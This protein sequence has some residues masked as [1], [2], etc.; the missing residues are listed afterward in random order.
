MLFRS[1]FVPARPRDGDGVVHDLLDVHRHE[2]LFR[3][4]PRELLDAPYRLRAVDGGG[5]DHAQRALDVLHVA[6]GLL[7]QL[8]VA[9]NGLEEV[10][11]VV[12]DAAGELAERGELLGLVELLLLLALDG[13][14]A[15]DGD[16]IGRASCRERV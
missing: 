5:F 11:E 16:E 8:R 7:H 2:L 9:E 12:G 14:V 6:R 10:V 15:E 13:D 1:L 4:Q 3:P